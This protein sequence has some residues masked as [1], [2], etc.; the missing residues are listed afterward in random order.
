M[1]NCCPICST[2]NTPICRFCK[3]CRWY[4]LD[5]E[6]QLQETQLQET[7]LYDV[8]WAQTYWT[9]NQELDTEKKKIEIEKEELNNKIIS[10]YEQLLTEKNKQLE[11]EKNQLLLLINTEIISIDELVKAVKLLKQTSS[12]QAHV[13][14]KSKNKT[15]EQSEKEE[16]SSP[17]NYTHISST[18]E[19]SQIARQD[20]AP[21]REE[22]ELATFYNNKDKIL[23]EHNIK[24]LPTD[25]EQERLGN[26]TK[27]LSRNTKGTYW[28]ITTQ[29]KK[30]FLVPEYRFKVNEYNY[31][32]FQSYF[33]CDGNYQERE[34]KMVKPA[35]VKP[36]DQEGEKWELVEQGAIEFNDKGAN[37]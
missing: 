19:K 8:E 11:K 27:F 9:R 3:K 21:T 1:S 16:D 29:E 15:V 14:D 33:A 12:E 23:S 4:L 5:K 31:Q 35:I 20:V 32:F 37:Y 18:H 7:Q 2:L 30:Y 17:N 34:I 6:T 10:L 36:L 25:I 22:Q 13:E 28:I 26:T 24:V